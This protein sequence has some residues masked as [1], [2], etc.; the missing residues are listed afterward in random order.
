[1][2]QNLLAFLKDIHP[3]S[4]ISIA[5][6][7]ASNVFIDQEDEALVDW[8]LGMQECRLSITLHQLI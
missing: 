5:T 8:I 4:T 2:C 3:F 7:S 6:S 1:M